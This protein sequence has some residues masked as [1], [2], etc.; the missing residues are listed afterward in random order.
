ME[1][2]LQS[3]NARVEELHRVLKQNVALQVGACM[4]LLLQKHQGPG[5]KCTSSIYGLRVEPVLR[6]EREG[7]TVAAS[8]TC[9]GAAVGCSSRP[10]CQLA[11]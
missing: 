11:A 1:Q 9:C 8:Q 5:G 3:A 7:G 10:H 6:K 4:K 2:A